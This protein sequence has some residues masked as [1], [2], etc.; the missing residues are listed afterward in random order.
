MD[1]N[2]L[3]YFQVLANIKHFTKAAKQI[4]ISQSA[5]SRS[6]SKLEDELGIT[7]FNRQNGNIHLTQQGQKFLIHTEYKKYI[8]Y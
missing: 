5:L 8:M 6:I 2:Q 4:S 3:K 1:F 7:L